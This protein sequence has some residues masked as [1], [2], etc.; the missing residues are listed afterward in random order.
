MTIKQLEQQ[1]AGIEQLLLETR[2]LLVDEPHLR[3]IHV[4][5]EYSLMQDR[6]KLRRIITYIN[7]KD[8]FNLVHIVRDLTHLIQR[9]H[10]DNADVKLV[11]SAMIEAMENYLK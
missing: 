6:D 5:R 8:D 9:L 3:N 4:M 7:A 1:L 11:T 10:I 2:Q